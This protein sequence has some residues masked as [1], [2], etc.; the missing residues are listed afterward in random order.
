MIPVEVFRDRPEERGGLMEKTGTPPEMVGVI[1]SLYP[2][3]RTL[4]SS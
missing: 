1:V 4:N 2:T 3:V